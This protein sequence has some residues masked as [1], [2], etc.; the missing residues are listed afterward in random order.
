MDVNESPH[1]AA[2]RVT[3]DTLTLTGLEGVDHRT[4]T[5]AF[6]TEL[7]RLLQDRGTP[8][9]AHGTE[10]REPPPPLPATGSARRLGHA[11][12]R[13]VHESLTG[14]TGTSGTSDGERGRDRP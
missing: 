9:A 7:T 12:A 1:P 3:I 10:N 4:V 11:L 6:R 14:A 2:V 5:D 13:A 8:A